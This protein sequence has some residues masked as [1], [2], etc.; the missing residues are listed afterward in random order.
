MK[1]RKRSPSRK[2]VKACDLKPIEKEMKQMTNAAN[3]EQKAPRTPPKVQEGTGPGPSKA[4]PESESM[5]EEPSAPN[6]DKTGIAIFDLDGCISDDA[7]RLHLIPEGASGNAD[8]ET[9]HS[10]CDKDATLS[11]GLEVLGHHRSQGH[12]IIFSTARTLSNADRTAQWIV[13]NTGMQPVEDFYMFM[14]SDADNRSTVECKKESLAAIKDMSIRLEL[15]IVA[16]YD[17]RSDIVSMYVNEGV[18]ASGLDKNGLFFLSHNNEGQSPSTG[19]SAEDFLSGDVGSLENDQG[20][21]QQGRTAADILA[22]MAMTFRE[23]NRVYG[24]N[25]YKVGVIMKALF[26]NGVDLREP[27]DYH[28]WHL[29]ELLIVKLTRFSNTGL[30][31]QDSIHDLAVYAAMCE[32]LVGTHNIRT[33]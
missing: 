20:Y 3:E 9:Y 13:A 18:A 4:A 11:K 16:A 22:E 25:A 12:L 28:M 30:N 2:T 24:D 19:P 15:P 29:F 6:Q 32:N 7:W 23:R 33:K 27:E 8:F 10:V 21:V 1:L 31:H 26:P 17:D 14:R 5:N